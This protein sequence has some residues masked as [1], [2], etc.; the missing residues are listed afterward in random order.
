VYS[1]VAEE[2]AWSRST[3]VNVPAALVLLVTVRPDRVASVDCVGV[4][5]CCEQD[6]PMLRETGVPTDQPGVVRVIID[7]DVSVNDPSSVALSQSFN[8][9]SALFAA[10]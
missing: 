5:V 1:V 3:D 8:P 7:G 2:K 10:G 6:V 4:V 9:A